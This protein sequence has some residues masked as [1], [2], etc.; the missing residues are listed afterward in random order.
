[1]DRDI[2]ISY[3]L[4]CFAV[5]PILAIELLYFAIVIINGKITFYYLV[6]TLLVIALTTIPVKV[7]F[8]IYEIRKTTLSA[9]IKLTVTVVLV[10]V[11]DS[12]VVHYIGE[13][14]AYGGI[15]NDDL[16]IMLYTYQFFMLLFAVIVFLR[17]LRSIRE[18]E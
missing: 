18:F 7:A 14:F 13:I 4:L 2:R 11:L 8:T 17:D 15:W 1:M 12:K 3:K 6:L 9:I 10:V 5:V 16:Y